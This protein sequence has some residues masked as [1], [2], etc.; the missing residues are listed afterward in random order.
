MFMG[1]FWGV[2]AIFVSGGESVWIVSA[3]AGVPSIVY[4]LVLASRRRAPSGSVRVRRMPLIGLYL[5]WLLPAVKAASDE[6]A[7]LIAIF[8]VEI[9]ASL[10]FQ[11]AIAVALYISLP[12]HSDAEQ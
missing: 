9:I 12:T 7:G 6:A 5:S 8:S 11:I 2:K 1:I 3:I 10:P 4:L